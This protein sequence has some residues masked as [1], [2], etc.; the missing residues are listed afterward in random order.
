LHTEP[1]LSRRI[2]TG[3]SITPPLLWNDGKWIRD[4]IGTA[5]AISKRFEIPPA[6]IEIHPGGRQNTYVDLV[7]SI[8]SIRDNFEKAFKVAPFV[9]LEDRT[10]QF[11]SNGEQI[12]DFWQ[13]LLSEK[14]ELRRHIGIVLDI[15]QLF[16]VT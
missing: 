16:T 10:G 1:S 5:I 11:V 13:T 3:T 8:I 4:F 6:G 9:V 2:K 7:R 14:R 15:Q 12:N